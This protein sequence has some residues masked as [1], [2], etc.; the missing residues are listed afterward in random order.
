MT[1]YGEQPQFSYPP[2]QRWVRDVQAYRSAR[3]AL[4]VLH[5]HLVRGGS[6]MF[7][8]TGVHSEVGQIVTQHPAPL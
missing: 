3:R 2:R 7:K 1:N 8:P 6:V 4:A 5:T